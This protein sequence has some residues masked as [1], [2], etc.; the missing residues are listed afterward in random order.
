VPTAQFFAP[1]GPHVNNLGRQPTRERGVAHVTVE[2]IFYALMGL[3]YLAMA[4]HLAGV[5]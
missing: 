4:L 3:A 2:P 1:L 5:I